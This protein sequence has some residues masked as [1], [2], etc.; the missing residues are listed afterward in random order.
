MGDA[1]YPSLLESDSSATLSPQTFNRIRRLVYDKAGIELKNGKESMV[2]ARLNKKLRENKCSTYEEYLHGVEADRTGEQ[3]VSLIDALTT[4]FTS[5]MRESAH[6][7]FLRETILPGLMNRRNIDVW[8]AA[9]AT[10]EEPYSLMFTLLDAKP[11]CRLLATDI[12]TRALAAA[13]RGIYPAERFASCR[14]EWLPKYL[15]RG[16]GDFTGLYQVKPEVS[17]RIEFRR[18]NLVEAFD[19]GQTFPLI[20]CRNVMIYFDRETQE[21]VVNRLARFLEPGGFLFV[22]HAERL[23][24]I[25]HSLRLVKPAIYQKAGSSEPMRGVTKLW[26]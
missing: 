23:I 16:D 7:D 11:E 4:N 8:C 6:F 1:S 20:S 26:K 12:S 25:D 24:G 9:A 18:L 3:L 22:G 17:Q 2:S 15:L 21:R 5:F 14:K 10:G 19:P 13:R